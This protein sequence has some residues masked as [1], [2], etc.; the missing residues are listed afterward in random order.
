MGAM[1]RPPPQLTV[2]VWA[3]RHRMRGSRASAE[4]GPWRTSRTPY[5]KNVMD[6]LSAVHPARR[7]V[8]M[9]GAQVGAPLA[10]TT[11]IPTAEGWA[12]MGSLI[13]GDALF[14][15]R[16]QPCRVIGVSLIMI[17]RACFTITFDDGEGV[18]CD[19]EHRWPMWDFTDREKPAARVLHTREMI[20]WVRTGHGSRY[21]YAIDCC[22]PAEL[23]DQDLLIHPY[24]WGCGWAMVPRP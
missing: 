19:G 7:V 10:I 23:P 13:V 22:A 2:S 20:Q 8:F 5:L 14:D 12:T 11:P 18:V 16:G 4:P 1:L 24:V 21:R 17:G 9:K 6:A 15:E 3:E